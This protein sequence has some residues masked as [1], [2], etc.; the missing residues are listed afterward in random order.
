MQY[1]MDV[2]DAFYM[3][4]EYNRDFGH[5]EELKNWCDTH[6][7][8]LFVLANSGC[9]RHCSGQTFHDNLVSHGSQI[10]ET[11]NLA[12]YNPIVCQKYLRD[13]AHWV[14]VLQGSWIRPEDLHNYEPLFPVVKLATRTH[15]NPRRVIQSYAAGRCNGNLLDLLE[16]SHS[17]SLHPYVLDN[18]KFPSDWFTQTTTCDKRCEKCDY[19]SS[20]LKM[21]L[22]HGGG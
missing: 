8:G 10:S 16:P 19:C 3:Q 22:A 7:K 6:G 1:L 18:V 11:A 17:Q 14:A 21:V 5:I 15:A 9:V 20:V 13:P 2:F 12:G 4:R